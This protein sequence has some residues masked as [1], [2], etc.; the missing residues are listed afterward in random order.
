MFPKLKIAAAACV[1]EGQLWDVS[2]PEP[3]NDITR[4]LDVLQLSRPGGERTGTLGRLNPRTQE[5]I[6][7]SP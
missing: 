4:G 5:I 1:T 6:L 2:D 3:A 7:G